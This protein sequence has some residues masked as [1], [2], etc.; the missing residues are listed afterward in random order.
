MTAQIAAE[1][2]T[3]IVQNFLFGQETTPLVEDQSFFE[4]GVIDSTGILE[5]VAFIERQYGIIV[6]D[7]E[8]IPENLDSLKNVSQFVSRKLEARDATT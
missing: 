3:F 5:L 8:L 6:A 1:I 7:P 2:R 4:R